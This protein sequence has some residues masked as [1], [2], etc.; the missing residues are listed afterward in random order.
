MS[1][2]PFTP[3]APM[4]PP[5]LWIENFNEDLCDFRKSWPKPPYLSDEEYG[6][7]MEAF[8][9]VCCDII[10]LEPKSRQ[11]YLVKRT[12]HSAIGRWDFGGGMRRGQTPKE[13]AIINLKRE[14]GIILEKDELTF[15]FQTMMYW[16]YRNPKPQ[17]LGEHCLVFTFCF[18]PTPEEIAG[19]KLDP[20]EYDIDHGVRLYDR[21][22]IKQFHES[23]SELLLMF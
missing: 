8:P 12:H 5:V 14:T 3:V 23:N 16:R 13:A 20:T 19:I 7:C 22:S 9:R 1:R 21:E 6:K 10:A 11:L 2:Q 18:V 4:Q 17:E 15:L